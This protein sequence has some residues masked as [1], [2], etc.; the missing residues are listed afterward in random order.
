VAE[1]DWKAAG[2]ELRPDLWRDRAPTLWRY[3]ELLPV[4]TPTRI[5]TLGEGMSPVLEMDPPAEAAGVR[6]FVKDE[7][8]Q[9]TGSF[10]ARGMAVAVARAVELGHRSLQAPTAGNAGLAL[11]AYAARAGVRA[12]VYAPDSVP[13]AFRA[14]IEG[15]GAGI[16]TVPGTIAEAGRASREAA[17]R[18]GAIDLS[19][20]REPNRVEGKKTMG[21]ELFEQFGGDAIPDAVVFPTGGGTGVV[22]LAKA[23]DELQRLGWVDRRPRIHLVQA[24]GCA[25]LV[26]AL[27]EGRAAAEPWDAEA[28]T[29][30][31]GLRVPS[32]FASE[33]VLSAV[34]ASGGT[35]IAVGD[36]PIRSAARS[37]L[38][39][40][41][42][43]SPEGA[44][45]WAAL[46][47][48][49]RTG[50]VREGERIVWFNTGI[51]SE[52]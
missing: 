16:V 47:E 29:I 26:R 4:A 31:A 45:A 39:R 5:V 32:P 38:R 19:T 12:T 3:F 24:E 14:R 33:R 25:P 23:F 2:R 1:Y 11:A 10:K 8:R 20:L 43:A 30:A 6:L 37:L 7:G 15:Y 51:G 44:A 9:P 46:P 35:G 13:A 50:A 49:A 40:G 41:I 28:R 42:S 17:A 18:D 36:D 34:R 21:F 48:L 27:A 22:G 52:G